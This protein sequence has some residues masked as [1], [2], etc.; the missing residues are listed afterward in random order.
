MTRPRLARPHQR[1]RRADRRRTADR[2]RRRRRLAPQ[3]RPLRQGRRPGRPGGRRPHR[4]GALPR[5][6][7]ARPVRRRRLRP[8]AVR[9]HPRRPAA[10]AVLRGAG[11]QL[12]HRPG[13]GRAG[14]TAGRSRR[15]APDGTWLHVSAGLGTSPYAP[16]RFA[17]PPE[18]TLL[19]LTA[20]DGLSPPPERAPAGALDSSTAPRGVAQLGSARRSGRRGRRFKS[21]HPDPLLRGRRW[22]PLSRSAGVAGPGRMAR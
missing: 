13:A 19:T 21:C 1:R 18:A 2:V 10:G 9:A 22:R 20:R 16:V 14:C 3:A 11:H 4:A 6:A 15:R 8:A 5:A 12:R 7:G 17:C